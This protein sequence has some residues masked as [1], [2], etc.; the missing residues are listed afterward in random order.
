[1]KKISKTL[2]IIFITFILLLVYSEVGYAVDGS[3]KLSLVLPEKSE[4][5]KKWENLPD[6]EKANVIQPLYSG[7]NFKNSIKRSKYNAIVNLGANDTIDSKYENRNNIVKDQLQTGCCWAFA[8]SS[9]LESTISKQY[10]KTSTEYSP[11]HIDYKTH[12]MYNKEIG[13]GG[14]ALL[15]LAY[16]VDGYGPVYE[17]D[18]EFT[19]VYDE[20]NNKQEQYYL[21]D[22]DEVNVNIPPK[23]II[24]DFVSF[25]NVYKVYVGQNVTYMGVNGER[26]TEDQVNE[27]RNLVKKHIKENGAVFASM[28]SDIYQL[29]SG[30]NASQGGYYNP[31]TKAYYN[32]DFSKNMNHAVTIVGWDDNF[33]KENF[34]EGKQPPKDGAYIILNSYG[35]TFGENGYFYVS[36]YDAFIEQWITGIDSIKDYDVD[37]KDYENIYQYDELG[38][39]MGLPLEGDSCF[40]ANVFTKKETEKQEYISKVGLYMDQT[41]GVEVY[42]NPAND[43]KEHLGQPVASYTGSNALEAGYHTIELSSPV[44][45]TGNKFVVA[46][47]YI[48]QEAVNVPLEI[49]WKSSGISDESSFFDTAKANPE[50]SFISLDGTDW[51]DVNGVKILNGENPEESIILKDTNAC[52]KAITLTSDEDLDPSV[53]VTGVKLNKT[54]EEMQVGDQENLVATITPTNA[55][56]QNV[57]WD[58]SNKTVA[59]ISE[60]GIITAKAEG[61]TTIT[62]TTEDGGYTASCTVT[63]KAKTNSDDDIYKDNDGTGG[64]GGG[65]GSNGSGSSGSG[66]QDGTVA[67]RKIPYAG[68]TI[69]MILAIGG[70]IVAVVIFIKYKSYDDVK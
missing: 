14:N 32:N 63:V 62:V 35:D 3:N 57:K 37:E 40:L 65:S 67:N 55:T 36:Y 6:E 46:V 18:F 4:T 29:E 47:K 20:K 30:G 24:E 68:N 23:A 10:N 61:T 50:E 66:S 52:I 25:P 28:Y 69:L 54:K 51:G 43:D 17:K 12:E 34:V 31:E 11:L 5:F 41:E 26:Y 38:L 58:S 27:I 53:K 42:I 70:L 7:T 13:N 9:M 1:M 56:N 16:S 60:K 45:I 39:S 8:F 44:K 33:K 48:N 59:T 21:K 2:L 19:K 15:A 64:T 49:N 22:P